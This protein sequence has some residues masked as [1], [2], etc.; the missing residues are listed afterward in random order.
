MPSSTLQKSDTDHLR[1]L[2]IFH[3][4]VAAIAALFSCM[5]LIHILVG[6][7]FLASPATFADQAQDLPPPFFGWLFLGVG[8]FALLSGW[9]V[10]FCIFLAGRFIAQRKHHLFCLIIA[11]LSCMFFPFGTAL[12]IFTLIVLLRPSVKAA[13]QKK[14][15]K[16]R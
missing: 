6:L 8:S 12:G 2:S 7:S 13:F 10:A 4:V 9:S 3:Y 1:L 15:L 5:F 14:G 16:K 11:G